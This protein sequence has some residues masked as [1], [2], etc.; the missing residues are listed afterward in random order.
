MRIIT[1]NL[2]GLRSASRKGVLPWLAEQ[3]ADVIALQETRLQ[4]RER[5]AEDFS[6]EGY[7]G[8]F[9]DAQAKGYSGVA[10]YLPRRP[11][12]FEV[13]RSIGVR[14][15]GTLAAG[16]FRQAVGDLAVPAVGIVG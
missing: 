1:L 7:T 12:R 2:N 4:E 5:L 9:V 11:D 6:I 14:R 15:R 3:N 16:G 13:G 8:Y 10:L